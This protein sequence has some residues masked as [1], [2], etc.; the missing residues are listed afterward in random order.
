VPALPLALCLLLIALLTLVGLTVL[1]LDLAGAAIAVVVGIVVFN[2]LA[3][4][5]GVVIRPRRRHAERADWP[6]EPPAAGAPAGEVRRRR[7]TDGGS[8]TRAPS[9]AGDRDRT[10]IRAADRR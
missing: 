3:V 8:K 7:I 9:S 10:E 5:Y 6:A 2:L 1:A 4:I